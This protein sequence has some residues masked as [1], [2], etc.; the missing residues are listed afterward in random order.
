MASVSSA[1]ATSGSCIGATVMASADTA[2]GTAS[3]RPASRSSSAVG[4][5]WRRPCTSVVSATSTAMISSSQT[6][7]GTWPVCSSASVSAPKATNSPCGMKIT[8]VTAKSSTVAVARS[9]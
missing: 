1:C 8:R 3:V 2:T 9:A 4:R 5:P 6:V 7:P